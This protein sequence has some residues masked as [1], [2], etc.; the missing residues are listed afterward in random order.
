MLVEGTT[1][2]K[3]GSSDIRRGLSDIGGGLSDS[4]KCGFFFHE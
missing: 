4:K 1:E 2:T 3:R